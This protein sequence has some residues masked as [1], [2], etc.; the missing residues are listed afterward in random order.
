MLFELIL[1]VF[2]NV[3]TLLVVM[4]ALFASSVPGK[5][6]ASLITTVVSLVA[7]QNFVYI[8]NHVMSHFLFWNNFVFLW[9][10]IAI[11]SFFVFTF[12]LN[13]HNNWRRG[14]LFKI[15]EWVPAV[16]LGIGFIIQVAASVSGQIF[17]AGS[18]VD[19]L[20]RGSGY[21]L[22][23]AG[24]IISLTA[25]LGYLLL[26]VIN[27]K[28]NTQQHWAIR[29]VY[30]TV[31]SAV[32]Y[33]LVT[34]VALPLITHGQ[35][36]AGL[37]ILTVDI[38]AIGFAV[39]IIK[40]R[41]LDVKIYVVR[42][43]VYVLSLGTLA[44][45]YGLVAFIISQFI[46]GYTNSPVQVAINISLALVLAFIFQPIKR[47]FDKI[48]NRIFYRDEYSSDAFFA[49]LNQILATNSDLK[50]LLVRTAQ[51]VSS[52]LKAEHAAFFIYRKDAHHVSAGAGNHSKLPTFDA[53][54]LDDYVTEHGFNIIITD[55]VKDSS[56]M[57]RLLISH[58][59]Y[60]LI[61]L[62][63]DQTILGYF[64][65]GDH[66]HSG[67]TRRDIRMLETID[68][69]LTLAIQN[70]S[71]VQEVKDLNANLEQR[72]DAA[73]RELRASNAQLQKLDEAK[74]EFISMASHQLRTPL[75]S[76]K[77]YISMLMDGDI[78]PVSKEQK[79]LLEEAFMSS[80]RMVRLIADFLN[81]SRLQTGKFIIDKHPS[82]LAKIVAQELEGLEPNAKAHNISFAY[83][84]PKNVPAMNLDE[85]KIQQVIMNFC[86]NAMYYSK[87]NAKIKVHLAVIGSYVEFTVKDTGIGVPV[88]EREQLFT[89]F[90]RATNARKQRP[91]GTGVGLFLA[92]KVIDAHG[93][94][95]I[96]ESQEGKG[97]TFGFRL[98]IK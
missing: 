47:F 15:T 95:I 84:R 29:T 96:F 93:G 91:D 94:K 6:R 12:Q 83:K 97:S 17:S 89:K 20:H 7:W 63:H 42:T 3:I 60:I 22:Y 58:R 56:F 75:T 32:L 55:H 92:K 40:G 48:T 49:E 39:S 43:V 33:G 61:P 54:K 25:V 66:E 52:A 41:L 64:M 73:T 68:G 37:G 65:L 67:Y 14:K 90:F 13:E 80:E 85:G 51:F 34:N 78:G 59:I 74:D 27:T 28:A 77:G 31:L 46:F 87:E 9:P 24:L 2:T 26:S 69:E 57:R 23:I 81:V 88:S 19:S 79:H 11:F 71:S 50:G 8:S 45:V 86:D 98:P 76:I 70:A 44:V 5:L 18:D 4:I 82:D 53:R 30:Y 72:I 36:Y 62:M 10:T 35:E 16:V 21:G 38:F 1:L